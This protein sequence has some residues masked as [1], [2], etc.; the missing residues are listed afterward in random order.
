MVI[1]SKCIILYHLSLGVQSSYIVNSNTKKCVS[2]SISNS[3]NGLS[4]FTNKKDLNKSN[5][6]LTFDI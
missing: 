3:I 5:S 1:A 6:F 4:D 2:I